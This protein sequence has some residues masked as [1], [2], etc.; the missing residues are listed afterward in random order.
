[1]P[2]L[3][4]LMPVRNGARWIAE[5]IG[6]VLTQTFRDFELIIIDDGSTDGT[7]AI[8][9]EFAAHDP[10]IVMIEQAAAGLVVALNTGL[11]QAR[12]PLIARLDADDVAVPARF[13]EQV[14]T[15]QNDPQLVLLGS[16]AT[17]INDNGR[18]I[19]LRRP[20]TD[21]AKLKESLVCG[22]PMVHSSVMFRT[23]VARAVGGYRAAFAAA[24]D[25]DLWLRLSEHGTI[26]NLL[27]ELIRYRVHGASVTARQ[28]LRQ[29]FAARLAL[30]SAELRQQGVEDPLANSETPIAME[31][32]LPAAYADIARLYRLL[33]CMAFKPPL[34]TVR[35]SLLTEVSRNALNRR[36]RKLAQLAVARLIAADPRSTPAALWWRLCMLR[37]SRAVPLLWQLWT[38][39][40]DIGNA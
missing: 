25:Y 21:A 35:A 29:M 18:V 6:S 13:T 2:Q 36:E 4:V 22:N 9:E 30:R 26:A 16:W 19:G 10:R 15:M 40:N 37:P 7:L 8:V 12:A 31:S 24:E 32:E 1:M 39:R 38:K 3:S 23:A 20:Q 14:A 11:A 5:A 33:S 28:P 34:D 27:R 17:E